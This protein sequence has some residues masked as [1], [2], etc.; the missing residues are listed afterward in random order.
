MPASNHN[1]IKESVY[2]GL[3][4]DASRNDRLKVQNLL[5][6]NVDETQFLFWDMQSQFDDLDNR[7][8]LVRFLHTLTSLVCL[9]LGSF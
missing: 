6:A 1:L 4:N 8:T 7:N 2:V 5:L 3:R 9:I